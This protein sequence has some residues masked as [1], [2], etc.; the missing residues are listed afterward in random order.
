MLNQRIRTESGT[1]LGRCRDVQFNT[2]TMHIEW[3]FPRKW[4]RW[5][6]ALPV[7]DIIEVRNDAIIVKHPLTGDRIKVQS[8]IPAQSIPEPTVAR[9]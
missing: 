9:T 4:F 2:D 8:E 7:S 6:M 1:S 3:I 5:G